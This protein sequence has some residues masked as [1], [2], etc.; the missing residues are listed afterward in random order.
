M[1]TKLKLTHAEA[2]DNG[3]CFY[4]QRHKGYVAVATI[5]E[6]DNITSKWMLEKDFEQKNEESHQNKDKKSSIIEEIGIISL[7]VLFTYI[8]SKLVYLFICK[9]QLLCIRFLLIAFLS[10]ASLLFRFAVTNLKVNER[11]F[12]GAEHMIANAYRKLNQIPN[13]EGIYS[14]SRFHNNCGTNI[15]VPCFY[16]I[17]LFFC[18]FI[19]NQLYQL[20]AIILT[21][22]VY[23]ILKRCGLLNFLQFFTTLPPTDR[24][25]MVAIAGMTTWYENEKKEKEK[26]TFLHRLFPRTFS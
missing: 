14:F 26:K 8:F 24:E 7:L 6:Q 20:L 25:L 15:F 4:S 1:R 22:I 11:K 17:P 12:H 18:T 16:F 19:S 10:L 5:D 3:I 21:F 9:H 2:M 13:L 23:C